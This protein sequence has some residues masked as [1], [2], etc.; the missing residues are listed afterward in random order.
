MTQEK[1]AFTVICSIDN[2]PIYDTERDNPCLH[3][4]G[5]TYKDGVCRYAVGLKTDKERNR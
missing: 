2:K 4:P 5:R 1:R 3:I